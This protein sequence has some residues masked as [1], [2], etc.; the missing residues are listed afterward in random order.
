MKKAITGVI[1]FHAL[2]YV[3]MI[4]A[5]FAGNN[6]VLSLAFGLDFIGMIV[7]PLILAVV[8]G[9]CGI[10]DN[11][12]VLKFFPSAAAA[13]GAAGL[14]RGVL[15][16]VVSSASG[17]AGAMKYLLISFILLTIW[18]M[19]FEV[20]RFLMNKETKYNKIDKKKRR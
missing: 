18:S 1:L 13:I 20:T 2:C 3:S 7:C 17:F 11:I 12:S 6:S 9:V 16:F 4:I 15:F 8:G 10:K 14:A 19:I 5:N